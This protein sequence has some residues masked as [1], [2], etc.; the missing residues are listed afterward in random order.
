MPQYC[1]IVFCNT[2][3]VSKSFYILTPLIALFPLLYEQEIPG[4]YIALGPANFIADPGHEVPGLGLKMV[5]H[6]FNL[7]E[8]IA[9]LK[10]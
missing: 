9:F 3:F 8:K 7:Q 6:P 1:S 2:T 4:F 10:K 5:G